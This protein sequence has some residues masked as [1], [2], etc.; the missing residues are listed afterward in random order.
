MSLE[1]R[2][3][4]RQQEEERRHIEQKQQELA[5]DL[6]TIAAQ[7]EGKRILRR[8]LENGDIF[9]PDWTPGEPGAFI[10]GKKAQA[11]ELWRLLRNC[12]DPHDCLDLVTPQPG[13]R[14][15]EREEDENA[16]TA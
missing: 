8:L 1:L 10:A 9:S 4:Q 15:T 7:P 5:S 13:F 2:R 3:Q 14:P 16:W 6:K 11:L 12:L